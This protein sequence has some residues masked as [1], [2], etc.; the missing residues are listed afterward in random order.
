MT[1]SDIKNNTYAINKNHSNAQ[2]EWFHGLKKINFS[3][4]DSAKF[5]ALIAHPKLNGPLIA[6]C[7]PDWYPKHAICFPPR[8]NDEVTKF[9]FRTDCITIRS[10]EKYHDRPEIGFDKTEK[11]FVGTSYHIFYGHIFD[12]FKNIS[13]PVYLR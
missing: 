13:D 10:T 9:F 11:D 8:I 5:L 6:V 12:E 1:E 7:I 4:R 2:L 3:S